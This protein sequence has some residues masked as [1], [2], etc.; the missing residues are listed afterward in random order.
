MSII[1]KYQAG[2]PLYASLGTSAPKKVDTAPI[3][4]MENIVNTK[5]SPYTADMFRNVKSSQDIIDM[6]KGIKD[7]DG[8]EN[9][10]ADLA[11]KQRIPKENAQAY[12]DAA[13][14]YTNHRFVNTPGV[15]GTENWNYQK[16]QPVLTKAATIVPNNEPQVRYSE[17][18]KLQTLSY[19]KK[20]N[21][22]NWVDANTNM[23]N[24]YVKRNRMDP[25]TLIN[26]NNAWNKSNK[27]AVHKKGGVLKH[28]K[29]NKGKCGKACNGC[30]LCKGGK[31]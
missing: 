7:S 27:I 22:P 11:A 1:K 19:G 3:T 17:T 31:I 20:T 9:M 18:G 15:D 12:F 14:K 23:V 8:V 26:A 28:Y 6:Y 16:T 10:S 21:I 5:V 25:N 30:K 13:A 29:A 24:M 2:A 4:N